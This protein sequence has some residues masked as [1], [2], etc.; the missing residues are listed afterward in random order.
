VGVTVILPFVGCD[1]LHAPL[2]VHVVAPLD[3]QVNVADS[4]NVIDVG[5]TATVTLGVTGKNGEPFVLYEQL[6]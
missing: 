6:K 2:A 4:P 5:E 3:D 1:P